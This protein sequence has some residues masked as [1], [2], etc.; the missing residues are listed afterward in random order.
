MRF[1]LSSAFL[2]ILFLFP[3]RAQYDDAPTFEDTLDVYKD[4]F[5]RTE[6]LHLTLKFDNREFQKTKSKESYHMAE[7]TC[8]VDSNFHVHHQVRVRARGEFRRDHCTMPPYWLNIRHAG[9]EAEGLKNT[10]KIKV[11]TRCK[12]SPRYEHLVLREYLV[13]KL[14]ELLTDFCF[15]TRL[16]R[17]KYIDTGRNMEESEDWGFLIEPDQMMAERNKSMITDSDRL[18][19]R[20]VNRE[21]MDLV[22]FF[23]YMIGHGDISVTGQQNLKILAQK[24]G[25]IGFIPVPYD[26]DYVGLVNA[27]YA[28]PSQAGQNLGIENVRERYYLGPCREN[29]VYQLTIDYLRS[30]REIMLETIMNFEYLPEKEKL[31]M[32]D[33]LESYF[34]SAERDGFIKYNINPTCR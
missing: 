21:T 22:S 13:Y 4:L 15:H 11:V 33:Y 26:F 10:I 27:I 31:D 12:S 2:L 23:C 17:I 9:I 6:P 19:V 14:Y 29:A 34:S 28:K 20:T 25:P 3:V 5:L 8:R 30:Y 18:T 24:E 7:L 16:V 32:V 1:I